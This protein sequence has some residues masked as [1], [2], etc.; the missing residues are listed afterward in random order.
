MTDFE[1]GPIVSIDVYDQDLVVQRAAVGGRGIADPGDVRRGEVYEFSDDS[2][3]RLAFVAANTRAN[4]A[5]LITLTYPRD[6]P[7]DGL[8]VRKHRK[9]FLEWTRRRWSGSLYLWFLEWQ[10]RGAPHIH[11]LLDVTR[12]A[13]DIDAVARAWYRIVAS[14]DLKHLAAGT[15]TEGV[16]NPGGLRNY[17][18]KEATK[19]RQ[20]IVPKEYRNVG[21]LWGHSRAVAPVLQ[22]TIEID[23]LSLR[24]M[25]KGWKYLPPVGHPLWSV[26]YGTSKLLLASISPALDNLPES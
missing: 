4:F 26:L 6:F 7:S 14:G 16:R 21:R 13:P 10:K 2:R 11:V 3:R 15:R 1:L 19:T 9:A 18:V 20:K 25:L 23:E 8:L 12:S 24:T 22:K 5:L 17:V